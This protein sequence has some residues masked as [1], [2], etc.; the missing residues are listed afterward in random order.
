MILRTVA[1]PISSGYSQRE[2]AKALGLKQREV[3]KL[4]D[5]LRAELESD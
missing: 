2:V 4:L 1:I 3:D 5:E